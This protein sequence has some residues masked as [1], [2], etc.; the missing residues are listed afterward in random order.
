MLFARCGKENSLRMTSCAIKFVK[1]S[2]LIQPTQTI[3]LNGNT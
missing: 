2:L 3:K 1:A